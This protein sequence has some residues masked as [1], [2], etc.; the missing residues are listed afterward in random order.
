MTFLYVISEGDSGPVKIGVSSNPEYRLVA[1]QTGNPRPLSLFWTK[2]F[3]RRSAAFDV[4]RE[5]HVFMSDMRQA[6]EWFDADPKTA[7]ACIV[8][9]CLP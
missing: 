4:E 9:G 8:G 3:G 5:A 7:V 2:R 6:G 1:L